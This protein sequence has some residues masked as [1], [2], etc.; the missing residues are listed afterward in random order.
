MNLVN[1]LIKDSDILKKKNSSLL[2]IA[3]PLWIKFSIQIK[4]SNLLETLLFFHTTSLTPNTSY[5]FLP[6]SCQSSNPF[7]PSRGSQTTNMQL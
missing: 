3:D 1:I 5:V 2:L 4:L 6:P 7:F